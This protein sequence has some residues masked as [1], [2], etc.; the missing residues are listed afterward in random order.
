M[1][2]C[3]QCSGFQLL[4]GVLESFPHPE[5]EKELSIFSPSPSTT[6]ISP[7][8]HNGITSGAFKNTH[9]GPI[10]RPLISEFLGV[11][12][13]HL[14]L[15][16]PKYSCVEPGLRLTAKKGFQGGSVVK[17]L[18]ARA[19]EPQQGKHTNSSD[20]PI[21][22]TVPKPFRTHGDGPSSPGVVSLVPPVLPDLR[23]SWHKIQP[24]VHCVHCRRQVNS[25]RLPSQPTVWFPEHQTQD[26]ANLT[27][28]SILKPVA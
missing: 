23:P 26:K 28:G 25:A 2:F 21:R 15:I 18:P 10:P 1:F 19:G 4:N 24:P 12:P 8:K 3:E 13:W 9:G 20:D 16:L 27:Q 14:F 6:M 22:C 11:R 17:N 7:W 5:L